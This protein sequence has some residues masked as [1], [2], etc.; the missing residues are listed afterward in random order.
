MNIRPSS[1]SDILAKME[2]E[3][4]ITRACHDGDKRNIN[5]TITEEGRKINGEVSVKQQEAVKQMMLSLT[6]EE[7][8]TLE[9]LMNKL[10][11]DWDYK[12][13]EEAKL[14]GPP[15]RKRGADK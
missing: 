4:L 3:G 12:F 11:S 14:Y 15:T 13:G 2:S 7:L 6:A 8:T 10:L 5:I 1:A 9:T